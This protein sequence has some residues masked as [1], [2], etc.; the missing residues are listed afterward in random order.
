MGVKYLILGK[1]SSQ[2]IA[3]VYQF[4]SRENNGKHNMFVSQ[5]LAH[6]QSQR[7]LSIDYSQ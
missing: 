5:K 1:S 7:P 6:S 4:W 3:C 2:N